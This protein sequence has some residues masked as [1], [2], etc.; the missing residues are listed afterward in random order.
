M[1]RR[2]RHLGRAHQVQVVLGGLVD[3]HRV[4][5]QE[6]GAVH[7][8]LTHE[9]RGD[10]RD[11]AL[12]GQDVHGAADQRELDEREVAEQVDEP[13]AARAHRALDVEHAERGAQLHVI[14]RREIER[15]HDVVVA[16]DLHRVLVGEA[17]GARGVR[18]VGRAREQRVEVRLGLRQ[19]RL[20]LLQLGADGRDL[21]DQSLLLV[22]GR[23]PDRLRGAVLCGPQLLDTLGERTPALV[24]GEELVDDVAEVPPREPG[25]ERVR[26]LTDLFDVEHRASHLDLVGFLLLL[27]GRRAGRRRLRTANPTPPSRP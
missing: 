14:L 7:R 25:T 22:A 21:G 10:H 3:V 15:R 17:V 13:R 24:G 1:Q 5:R 11:E 16:A 20:E 2:E 6:T 23:S 12:L 19:L 9:H 26:I 27:R 8:L 4:R 18:H